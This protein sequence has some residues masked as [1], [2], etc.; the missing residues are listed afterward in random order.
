MSVRKE[1]GLGRALPT[2]PGELGEVGQACRR[3]GQPR[4]WL[5][6]R[7]LDSEGAG[8]VAA[9]RACPRGAWGGAGAQAGE[10]GREGWEGGEEGAAAAE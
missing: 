7:S 6:M 1:A 9:A 8:R 4:V 3:R 10:G 2:L 5:L